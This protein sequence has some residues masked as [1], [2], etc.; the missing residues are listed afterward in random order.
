MLAVHEKVRDTKREEESAMPCRVGI[1]TDPDARRAYW[2]SQVAGFTGWR[3]RQTFSSKA[4]AQE[5]E[6]Q[7]A[8][9]Y[10]CQAHAGGPEAPGMWYVYRFDYTRTR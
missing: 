7:Y 3:I 6:T 4:K 1:T 9:R 5:Y 10:G 2:Q 8:A